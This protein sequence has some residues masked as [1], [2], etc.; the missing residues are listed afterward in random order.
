[1]A[2][3]VAENRRVLGKRHYIRQATS[4]N[5]WVDFTKSVVDSYLSR[6][7]K[8]FCLVINH[9]DI[10]NDAYVIPYYVMAALLTEYSLDPDGRGWSGTIKNNL[11]RMGGSSIAVSRYFNAYSLLTE[12]IKAIDPTDHTPDLLAG[13]V[14]N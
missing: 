7:G 2:S 6:F 13:T 14:E 12:L 4:H 3:V 9:S 10:D 5:Y 8:D 1:M 11:L